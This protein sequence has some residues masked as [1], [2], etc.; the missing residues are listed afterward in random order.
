MRTHELK[1]PFAMADVGGVPCGADVL[2]TRLAGR[3]LGDGLSNLC[4]SCRS[5]LHALP[6]AT[7]GKKS[8]QLDAAH[9][10]S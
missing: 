4:R 10:A 9:F 6:S 8:S 3:P 1:I 2:E 7:H 5:D